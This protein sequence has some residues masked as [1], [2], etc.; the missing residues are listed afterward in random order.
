MTM[1][2]LEIRDDF[3]K[4][5]KEQ[6]PD[7]QLGNREKMIVTMAINHACLILNEKGDSDE[8]N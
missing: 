6:F 7:W 1:N 3:I 5:M 4:T 2:N 8:H